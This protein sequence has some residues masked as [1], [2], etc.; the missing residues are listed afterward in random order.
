M[1]LLTILLVFLI[2]FVLIKFFSTR[3]KKR[4]SKKLRRI[5]TDDIGEVIKAHNGSKDPLVLAYNRPDL[6]QVPQVRADISQRMREAITETN[7]ED[8]ELLERIVHVNEELDIDPG[9]RQMALNRLTEVSRTGPSFEVR[10]E[11][12]KKIMNDPQNVHDPAVSGSLLGVLRTMDKNTEDLTGLG[13]RGEID[14]VI[15]EMID[16][17]DLSQSRA[18]MARR[19][20]SKMV[21]SKDTCMA[22]ENRTE[23]EILSTTWKNASGY[24]ERHNIILG[25]ADA[26]TESGTV[27]ING[28]VSRVL[29]ANSS[30]VSTGELKQAIYSYAGKIMNEGGSFMEVEKYISEVPGMPED[31]KEMVTQECRAVFDENM[32]PS[33]NSSGPSE[34]NTGPGSSDQNTSS[35]GQ[36]TET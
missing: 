24:T 34:Q 26:A 22:Y 16:R 31:Q 27:C 11:D 28:R 19:T 5:A 1:S 6:V 20:L 32:D 23:S 13:S 14:R 29:G 4:Q 30:Q 2:L 3:R 12:A 7:Y 36:N 25:L 35:S 17:G 9:I 33:P 18:E 8:I 21:G 10:A 15:R